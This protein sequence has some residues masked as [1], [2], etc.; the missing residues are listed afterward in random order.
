VTRLAWFHCF[1]GIAGDMALGSLLHA[2]APVDEVRAIVSAVPVDGW[3]LDVEHVQRGGIGATRAVVKVDDG[4][5]GDH[6]AHHPHRTFTVIAELLAGATSAMPTRVHDRALATFRALAEA[7]GAVHQMPM[8]DVHFHEVGSIDAIVDV[9]GTCAA[10][11]LLGVDD[12]RASPVAQGLAMVRSEHGPIPAPAPAVLALLAT[13]GAPTYGLD[14][15][16]ELTT[17]TGAALLAALASGWGPLPAMTVTSIGY[18]AGGRDLPA[19][20]NVTQ[21]VIGDATNTGAA[22]LGGGQ[23]VLQLEANV[24]DATG[25]VLAH[26]IAALLAAGAHDAWVTPIVM[27]KGR[28]AHTVHAL[29]E[30]SMAD[31][32][33]S[34]L[35]RETG[36]LGLR[37]HRIE[38]WPQARTEAT[39][40]VD[41]HAV[42]VKIG[43][44][45]RVKVEHDDAATAAHALG[46]PLREVLRR[47][48]SAGG[49]P[50]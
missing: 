9:V 11:E 38:R 31:T 47:A 8:E 2:G 42:R 29:C 16:F 12:V 18:G 30:P 28:P 17:P 5:E 22:A 45:G 34:V 32:V 6:H 43:A 15:A 20:P 44:G 46:L 26:T 40:D 35:S 23:P 4:D 41:G 10:L 25:E 7:E 48:E 50:S 33:G 3:V 21:V 37:G 24:D 39:V 27:K 19:R 14:I 13:A 36:S 49:D 1:S